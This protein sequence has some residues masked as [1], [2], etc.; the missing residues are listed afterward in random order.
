MPADG[1]QTDPSPGTRHRPSRAA[2]AA[3][4]AG[5]LGAGLAWAAL[6]GG[7]PPAPPEAPKPA[8]TRFEVT[9]RKPAGPP[10]VRTGAVDEKGRP[11]TIACGV[12]HAGREP[13]AQTHATA[14]LKVFHQGLQM[15]HG[16]L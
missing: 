5:V 15:R 7:H 14:D 13:N 9:V 4:T 6:P 2:A 1:K 3:L 11:V 8:G 12:C 16:D 10:C